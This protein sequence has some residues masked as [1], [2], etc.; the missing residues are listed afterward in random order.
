MFG[1]APK[2]TE[3][4][5]PSCD[6]TDAKMERMESIRV[7][8]P[9]VS[10]LVDI[11]LFVRAVVGVI[12]SEEYGI[13]YLFKSP[14]YWGKLDYEFQSGRR[15]TPSHRGLISPASHAPRSCLSFFLN[16]DCRTF[17][18]SSEAMGNAYH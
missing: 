17:P 4:N 8:D 5:V 14:L 3:D 15:K 16:A 7:V 18:S 10:C 12:G 6:P 11:G 2:Q 13:I 9:V 1:E